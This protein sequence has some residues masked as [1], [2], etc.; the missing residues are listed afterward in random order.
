MVGF[1]HRVSH[2]E[3]RTGPSWT[4]HGVTGPARQRLRGWCSY[5]HQKMQISWDIN[6]N[7]DIPLMV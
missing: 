3:A 7:R 2:I 4:A 1:R 6:M 5:N